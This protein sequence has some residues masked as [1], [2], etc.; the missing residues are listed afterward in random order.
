MIKIINKNNCKL[1]DFLSIVI[2]LSFLISKA[3]VRAMVFYLQ[4]F[5]YAFLMKMMIAAQFY[6]FWLASKLIFLK[7]SIET[8]WAFP[9]CVINGF[10]D[11]AGCANSVNIAVEQCLINTTVS[12]GEAA[13]LVKAWAILIVFFADD[14][15]NDR[16]EEGGWRV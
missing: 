13:I 14:D 1:L 3:S 15:A 11:C 16:Y 7:Y 8:D 2:K 9:K 10:I 5:L 4:P 6:Y 12:P